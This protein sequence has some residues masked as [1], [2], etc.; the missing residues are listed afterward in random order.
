MAATAYDRLVHEY[1]VVDLGDIAGGGRSVS[2][3][4]PELQTRALDLETSE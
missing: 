2:A 3:M 1:G 4:L